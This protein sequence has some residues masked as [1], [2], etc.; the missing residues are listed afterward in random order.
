MRRSAPRK[1]LHF[2]IVRA[3]YIC[4][5][6]LTFFFNIMNFEKLNYILKKQIIETVESS[7]DSRQGLTRTGGLS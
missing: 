2:C 3:V 5:C 7:S 4:C 1:I 6:S